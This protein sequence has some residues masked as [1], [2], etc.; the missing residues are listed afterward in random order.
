MRVIEDNEFDIDMAQ[1]KDKKESAVQ[2]KASKTWLMLRLS[3]KSKLTAF[4]KIDDGKNLKILFEAPQANESTSQPAINTPQ[5]SATKITQE[6]EN[7]P[8]SP[9]QDQDTTHDL[10]TT[11]DQDTAQDHDND[12]G[13]END[14]VMA[15]PKATEVNDA[16]T[17]DAPES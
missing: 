9:A 12:A 5:D 11:Y 17:I 2:T 4:E 8:N 10:D 7:E 15:E 14:T 16:T 1:T 13:A 6:N 3:A